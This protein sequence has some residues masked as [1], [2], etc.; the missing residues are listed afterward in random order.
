MENETYKE[1]DVEV[2][3]FNLIIEEIDELIAKLELLK[4]TKESFSFDVDDE[5]ELL[6][7][8]D[9]GDKE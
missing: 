1:S 6:I 2:F 3:E 8:F 5:N 7:N 4:E 9:K